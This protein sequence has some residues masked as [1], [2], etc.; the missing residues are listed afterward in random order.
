M[1]LN[2]IRGYGAVALAVLASSYLAS[3]Y[4]APGPFYLGI[5]WGQLRRGEPEFEYR[6]Q[7]PREVERDPIGRPLV[8]PL[9]IVPKHIA[10]VFQKRD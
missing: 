6:K 10:P 1:R 7:L 3:I 5:V 4:G 9:A 2:W 8:C